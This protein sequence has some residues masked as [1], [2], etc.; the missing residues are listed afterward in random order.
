VNDGA[1]AIFVFLMPGAYTKNWLWQRLPGPRL[2]PDSGGEGWIR[3]KMA[4]V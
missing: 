4:H 1:D 2:P 3:A